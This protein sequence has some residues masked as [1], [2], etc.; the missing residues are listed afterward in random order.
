MPL[1]IV[2]CFVILVLSLSTFLRLPWGLPFCPTEKH[3][4]RRL[5]L[6]CGYHARFER[7]IVE[8]HA[9]NPWPETPGIN[10]IFDS[11]HLKTTRLSRGPTHARHSSPA[12]HSQLWPALLEYF[13]VIHKS[14][15]S[16]N[17]GK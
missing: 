17:S 6:R 4:L 8:K 15:Y 2:I 14:G 11:I 12:P 7:K 13:V 3:W 16:A 1:P 10:R 5:R 9:L